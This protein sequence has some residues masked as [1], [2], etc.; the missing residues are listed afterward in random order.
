MKTSLV[1]LS[2][3][4]K[5][6]KNTVPSTEEVVSDGAGNEAEEETD[7]LGACSEEEVV[8]NQAPEEDADE[9]ENTNTVAGKEL[10][11]VFLVQS[12]LEA[13][14]LRSVYQT[15]PCFQLALA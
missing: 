1:K 14:D 2:Q 15:L 10:N 5:A 12:V 8:S 6:K 4:S 13:G 11:V 7:T 3:H 9:D